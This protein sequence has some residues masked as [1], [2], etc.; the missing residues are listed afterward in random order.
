MAGMY[1]SIQKLNPLFSIFL[2]LSAGVLLVSCYAPAIEGGN[3]QLALT[4]PAY[5]DGL[6]VEYLPPTAIDG[7]Q[8]SLFVKMQPTTA[9][10][11]SSSTIAGSANRTDNISFE[12]RLFNSQNNETVANVTYY[13]IAKKVDVTE[14]DERLLIAD[15]F[16]SPTGPLTVNILPTKGF[17][18]VNSTKAPYQD[19]WVTGR[20]GMINY[21]TPEIFDPGLYHFRVEILS[22]DKPSNVFRE[23]DAPTFNSWLS[24]PDSTIQTIQQ[25][26][27]V[28][29]ITL[30]SYYDKIKQ[31]DFDTNTKT[32]SWSMPFDWNANRVMTNNTLVHEEIKIPKSFEDEVGAD[33]FN[34]S[35]NNVPI[36]GRMFISDPYSSANEIT[37]HI[38]LNKNDIMNRAIATSATTTT[39]STMSFTLSPTSSVNKVSS[40]NA[41]TTI[42][43]AEMVTDTGK[44]KV[45][46]QRMMPA[47][48]NP[49]TASTIRL[50]FYDMKSAT[51]ISSD[52]L[53]QLKVFDI[54]DNITF[55]NST[56]LDAKGGIDI[57]KI[58]FPANKNY[59]LEIEIKGLAKND[60][61]LIDKSS[62]G[63]SRGIV[64]VPEFPTKMFQSLAIT[65]SA[66]LLGFTILF[67][68]RRQLQN[69]SSYKGRIH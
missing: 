17:L 18:E 10:S 9:S 45:A 58:K 62:N 41:T 3:K 69:R 21:K 49:N 66:L 12:T 37:F 19:A 64:T 42:S 57:Q 48:F 44:I 1:K 8:L 61:Q 14:H 7:R 16:Q 51:R 53:Y 68:R 63:I 23:V 11:P 59:R 39:T 30:I 26:G 35:V 32:L 46:V 29:N 67:Q 50:D 36:G 2:T 28:Y 13:V 5:G 43:S 40:N 55:Y 15:M 20:N 52:V 27:K 25:D 24:I 31:F 4:T 34:G 56:L 38:I 33:V 6:A 65:I 47:Q 22:I 60:G 54:Q